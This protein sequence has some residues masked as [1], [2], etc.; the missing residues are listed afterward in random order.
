MNVLLLGS[1]GRE[2]AFASALKRSASIQ[3]LFIAPGNAGT[4]QCGQNV[5]LNPL[6]FESIHQ[7]CLE[8]SIGLLIP[9]NEDPLVAG[10][11]DFIQK[12]NSE[13]SHTIL[14]AGPNK[15][16][17]QLEGSKDFAKE[18]M[19]SNQIPTA[20]YQTF[21]KDNIADA[22]AY[23][24][25]LKPPYVLKAD[26]LAAGKGVIITENY[27]EAEDTLNAMILGGMFGDASASVVVE[28]FLNG[29]E[30]SVFAV[31]DGK[32]YK[33]MASAKDYKRI[34]DGDEGPNTG[35][36][37]AISPVPFADAEFMEKVEKQI[38][39]PSFEG[40]IAK[41][42]PYQGFLFL[43]LMNDR[44]NPKV[45]EYNV[46]MGDP[47]T[48]AIFPRLKTDM[49]ELLTSIATGKL[50][51]IEFAIDE[52]TAATIFLVSAGYPGSIEKGKEIN[53]S[54]VK[55]SE[56]QFIFHAGTKI[57]GQKIVTNGGRVI[58]VT[59]L[60]T[61]ISAAL[62]QSHELAQAIDFEGKFYRKDIGLDLLK[63]EQGV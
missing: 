41:G 1:G 16:C 52:R 21:T 7:F 31:S 12:K 46:R 24:K 23:L 56:S 9:G 18:F 50:D 11:V 54:N 37:G 63:Y 47:E 62:K 20:S 29:I 61:D 43:G 38:V 35:G 3:N 14:V 6:D 53:L 49:L 26:G 42:N 32:S 19:V 13:S 25:S 15:F 5:N 22:P 57:D 40:L 59:S 8:N 48:E 2:H 39:K 58:A 33:I 28:E 30:I 45:I 36:M 4:A 17:S 44:G 10:I 27:Q 55:P 51:Q 60:D 34:Y